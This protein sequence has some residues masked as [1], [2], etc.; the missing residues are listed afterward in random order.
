MKVKVNK[1]KVTVSWSKIKNTKKTK[2]LLSQIKKVQVQCATD[3]AFKN[4][5]ADKKVGKNKTKVV[6]KLMKKTTYYIRTRY[7]GKDGVSKWTKVKA[8]KTKKKQG[9]GMPGGYFLL[10]DYSGNVTLFA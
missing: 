7:I 2:K 6:L 9:S 4:V 1:N 8:V 5:V 3:R 10:T